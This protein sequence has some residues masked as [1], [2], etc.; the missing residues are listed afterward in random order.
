MSACA[1]EGREIPEFKSAREQSV[2]SRSSGS[3]GM[4]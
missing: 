4:M 2:Y 1:L 3:Y